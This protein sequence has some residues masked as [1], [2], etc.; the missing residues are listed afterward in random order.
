[1]KVNIS[2]EIERLINYGLKR[3]LIKAS[4]DALIKQLKT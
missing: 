1:M 4:D 2:Y 3:G